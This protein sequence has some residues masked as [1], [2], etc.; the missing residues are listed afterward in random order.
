MFSFSE[1]IVAELIFY[2]QLKL[3]VDRFSRISVNSRT[4]KSLVRANF[5]SLRKSMIRVIAS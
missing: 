3:N 1:F 5:A 4:T 2:K